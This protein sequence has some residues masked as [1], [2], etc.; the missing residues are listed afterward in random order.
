MN[1]ALRVG[2]AGLGLM[3]AVHV[4]ALAKVGGAELVAVAD[5]KEERRA[6][7]AFVP[8]NLSALA[9]DERLFDAGRVTAYED[10]AAMIE[11]EALD[12]VVICTPTDSHVEMATAALARGANVLLEKPVATKSAEVSRLMEAEASSGRRVIP[13]M[14][15]RFWPGWAWLRERVAAGEWGGLCSLKLARLGSRPE[16]SGAFYEDVSRTGGAIFD[17]HVHD[18]DFV[19]WLLGCPREVISVGTRDHVT[20]MYRYGQASLQVVAEGGWLASAGR[21]FRMR[22]VAEFEEATAEFDLTREPGVVVMREGA[23]RGVEAGT[24]TAYEAQMKRALECVAAW[25]RGEAAPEHP[26]LREALEVTRVVEAEVRSLASGRAE[27]C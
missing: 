13:A 23:Q 2:V 15:M 21:G 14:C 5:P 11:R 12:L 20:T 24:Q 18:V 3:G 19:V 25:K 6:G 16:W 10:A 1:D 9:G 4:R 26:T 17:L 22:F 8:G 7:R 27:R